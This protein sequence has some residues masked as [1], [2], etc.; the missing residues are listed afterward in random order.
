[1][2]AFFS[3]G[4]NDGRTGTDFEDIVFVLTNRSEVWNEIHNADLGLKK[5]LEDSFTT[6]LNNKY[7]EEWVMAHLEPTFSTQQSEQLISGLKRFAK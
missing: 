4:N 5:Y 1:M 3:R 7:L 2:E 6:L